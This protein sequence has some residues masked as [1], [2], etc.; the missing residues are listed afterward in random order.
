MAEAAKPRIRVRYSSVDG[1]GKTDSFC[2]IEGARKFA[3]RHVGKHAEFGTDYAVSCDGVGKIRVEGCTLAELFGRVEPEEPTDLELEIAEFGDGQAV[4]ESGYAQMCGMPAKRLFNTKEDDARRA[5]EHAAWMAVERD[6][7][8]QPVHRSPGCTC[9]A[10]QL[11][12]VGCECEA[13][14]PF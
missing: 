12:L 5:A 4:W 3:F 2:A 6:S 11:A 10:M 8:G 7:N 13:D 14:G 9:S 1:Y